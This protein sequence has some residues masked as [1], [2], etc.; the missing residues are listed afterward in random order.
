MPQCGEL[1][2][3]PFLCRSTHALQ[4]LGHAWAA[5]CRSHAWLAD[6]LLGPGS[7]LQALRGRWPFLVRTLHRYYTRV[8]LLPRVPVGRAAIAFSH[9]SAAGLRRRCG[10][11]LPVLVHDVSGRARGLRL[12]RVARGLRAAAHVRV[13]FPVRYRIDTLEFF[14]HGSI[15]GLSVPPVYASPPTFRLAVQ[16]SGSGWVATPFL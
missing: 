6:V 1:L 12:R 2:L 5:P 9:R 7:S 16:D 3:L 13:V 11:D 4:P 14:F 8:R 10:P 15:P